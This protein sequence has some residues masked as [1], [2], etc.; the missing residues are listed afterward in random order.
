MAKRTYFPDRGDFIHLNFSPSAGHEMTDRHYGLVLSTASFSRVT[1]FA[2]VC[3]ITSRIRPWPFYVLV[4]KGILPP[5]QGVLVDGNIA[6][7]QVKSVDCRE[8][9][10]EFVCKAPDDIL[11]EVLARVRA[12]IDSD[13]VMEELGG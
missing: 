10:M 1:G 12:I 5:K 9:E 13:D 11:D 8:R 2:L 7:D 4:P 6:T 3:P